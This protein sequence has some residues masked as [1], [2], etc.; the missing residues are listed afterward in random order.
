MKMGKFVIFCTGGAAYEIGRRLWEELPWHVRGKIEYIV[1]IDSDTDYVGR[2]DNVSEGMIN[3]WRRE[4]HDNDRIE[5][6]NISISTITEGVLTEE[7]KSFINNPRFP[8]GLDPNLARI[9]RGEGVN[10][11]EYMTDEYID[12]FK[13][14]AGGVI[15][16][17]LH[18]LR[19]SH[20]HS[21]MILTATIG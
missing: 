15:G 4:A 11:T 3:S 10:W 20:S 13:T 9:R 2:F 7:F 12:L 18:L 16:G 6:F 5:I 14:G 17:V 19:F 8:S 1:F 21:F